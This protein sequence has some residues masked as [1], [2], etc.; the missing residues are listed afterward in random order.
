MLSKLLQGRFINHLIGCDL[1]LIVIMLCYNLI[2]LLVPL[3]K[4]SL[5]QGIGCF[6]IINF[7]LIGLK[8][9]TLR[10]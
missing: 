10:P 8:S 2:T 3:V 4:I 6:I 7:I 1:I 5:S 9:Y